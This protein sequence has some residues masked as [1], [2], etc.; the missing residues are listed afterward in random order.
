MVC[1]HTLE[2]IIHSGPRQVRKAITV[3]LTCVSAMQMW[4]FW[5]SLALCLGY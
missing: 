2:S 1:G 3:V 5:K 4:C